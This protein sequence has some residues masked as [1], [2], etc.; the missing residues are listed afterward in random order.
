MKEPIVVLQSH[1]QNDGN[2]AVHIVEQEGRERCV[3]ITVQENIPA[4]Q[5]HVLSAYILPA[6]SDVMFDATPSC[7][8]IID[9]RR[10]AENEHIG[11][12]GKDTKQG[13][14]K[15]KRAVIISFAK[16]RQ[17]NIRQEQ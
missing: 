6:N 8:Y 12:E 3:F 11:D 15:G 2:K 14:D 13:K 9:T 1:T 7:G 5:R 10:K 16:A 17:N 4:V